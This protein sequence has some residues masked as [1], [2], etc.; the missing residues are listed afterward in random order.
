MVLL[1]ED[2]RK[3]EDDGDALPWWVSVGSLTCWSE[4]GKRLPLMPYSS[5]PATIAGGDAA[6]GQIRLV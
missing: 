2:L 6:A 5:S 3:G 4:M 1:P